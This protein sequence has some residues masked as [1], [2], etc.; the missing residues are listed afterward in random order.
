MSSVARLARSRESE[1]RIHERSETAAERELASFRAEL[2]EMKSA[3]VDLERVERGILEHLKALG[4]GMLSEAM[5]RADT[6]SPE[7]E[8]NGERW[9]NRRA[10]KA[11]LW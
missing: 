2:Q 1:W 11:T 10:Q 4:R 3:E 5:K 8:I 7:V 9:G 6:S